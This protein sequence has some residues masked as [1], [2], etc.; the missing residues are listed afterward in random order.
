M[1]P[2]TYWLVCGDYGM[3]R[4]GSL[5]ACMSGALLQA[6]VRHVIVDEAD[7]LLGNGYIKATER[8]L[9]V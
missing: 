5:P 1:Y 8:I 6:R 3:R 7:L 2:F 9:T 4:N